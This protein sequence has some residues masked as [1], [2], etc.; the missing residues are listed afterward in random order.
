MQRTAI[1]LTL[2]FAGAVLLVLAWQVERWP[3]QPAHSAM[4]KV[5]AIAPHEGRFYNDRDTIVVRNAHGTGQF[6]MRDDDVRCHVGDAV[7]VEQRGITLMRV[8][9]TCR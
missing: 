9:K 3:E 1:L 4:A 8:A 7:P 6:T 5:V 2:G